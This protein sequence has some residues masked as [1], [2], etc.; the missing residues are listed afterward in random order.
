MEYNL[1]TASF[2]IPILF[3]V[4]NRI[5]TTK[6]VFEKIKS[7]KPKFLFIA[8]DGPRLNNINDQE[9]FII[10]EWILENI[11]WN[12]EIKTLFR[13]ENLGCGLAISSAISWFFENVEMGIILEDDCLP[14]ISFFKFCEELLV[15]YKDD[16]KV[17][18]ICAS[19]MLDFDSFSNSSYIFS[20]FSLI[21]GWATWRRA[22]VNYDYNI[23]DWP[24]FRKNSFFNQI[25]IP[26]RSQF[27]FKDIFE[28]SYNNKFNTW[29]YQWLYTCWKFNAKSIIP[30]NNL[31]RNIGFGNKSTHTSDGH[32]FSSFTENEIQFPLRHPI[33]LDYIKDYD[34]RLA[35]TYFKYPYFTMLKLFLLK[36]N[37]INKINLFRKRAINFFKSEL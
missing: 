29:D 2:D 34:K 12:C 13:E 17:F 18:S 4:F 23:N 7:I 30:Q 21:W 27:Y 26:Y 20:N 24:K 10:R 9:V 14:S 3:L 36:I 11:D 5:D 28:K 16:K 6:E 33:K 35:L 1:K 25:Q 32:L 15:K 22:W 8:S 19:Q 31:V 37:F